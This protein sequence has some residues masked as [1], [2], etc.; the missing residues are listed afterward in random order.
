MTSAPRAMIL[1][2]GFGTRLESLTS[3]RPKPML[4]VCGRPLVEWGLR[5]LESYGV[6]DVVMN[7]HH[8]GAQIRSHMDALDDREAA[9]HFSQEEG[10]ILGTG[11]GLLRA[12]PYLDDGASPVVVANGKIITDIDLDAALETH[13]VGGHEATMV[14]REDREQVWK[15]SLQVSRDGRLGALMGERL[16]DVELDPRPMMFTGVHILSPSMFERIPREGAPCIVRTAYLEAFR[17]GRVGVHVSDR[18]WWEHST[19][20]RYVEGVRRV[21]HGE[22]S[23]P[24]WDEQMRA[25]MGR[26][27]TACGADV[28]GPVWLGPEVD[29]GAGTSLRG[30]CQLGRGARLSP[31]VGLSRAVVW[32]GAHVS[33]DLSGGV[34]T[35]RGRA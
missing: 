34:W 11:G 29:L 16:P 1:A 2:A 26:Q 18:Y 10:E 12:R 28:D 19:I 6:R 21:L 30:G 32:S 13:R 27:A 4:P 24:W 22:V 15:G 14:L 33:E 5:W 3:L 25:E 9:V 20:E 8:L 23:R 35:A 17:E 7:L 31:G